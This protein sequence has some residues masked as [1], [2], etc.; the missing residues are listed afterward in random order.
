[1][2]EFF[3]FESLLLLLFEGLVPLLCF[4]L[5]AECPTS[6]SLHVKTLCITWWSPLCYFVMSPHVRGGILYHEELASWVPLGP[7]FISKLCNFLTCFDENFMAC[8]AP[9]FPYHLL[10]I[11]GLY[12]SLCWL[13]T[14]G[15]TAIEQLLKFPSVIPIHLRISELYPL[16]SILDSLYLLVF[17]YCSGYHIDTRSGSTESRHP[18][19]SKKS[20]NEGFHVRLMGHLLLRTWPKFSPLEA[21]FSSAPLTWQLSKPTANGWHKASLATLGV[22]N[23]TVAGVG[24]SRGITCCN[25]IEWW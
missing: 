11:W 1:M 16:Q 7:T 3:C 20:R 21:M 9:L 6:C 24:F 19:L 13:Y 5:L 25:W 17:N 23:Q 22:Q 15:W 14:A 2:V 12:F 10:C 4:V 8:L 18:G